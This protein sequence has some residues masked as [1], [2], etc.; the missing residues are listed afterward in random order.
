[1]GVCFGDCCATGL[2]EREDLCHAG[3]CWRAAALGLCSTGGLAGGERGLK[4]RGVNRGSDDWS[5]CWAGSGLLQLPKRLHQMYLVTVPV[6]E[7]TLQEKLLE[8]A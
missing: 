4:C 3:A 5:D 2:G 8:M 1:M 6:H 7:L